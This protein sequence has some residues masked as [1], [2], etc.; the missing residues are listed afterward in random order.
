VKVSPRSKKIKEQAYWTQKPQY[1]YNELTM[2]IAYK[3]G[4]HIGGSVKVDC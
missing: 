1:R 2:Q 3:Y 4:L